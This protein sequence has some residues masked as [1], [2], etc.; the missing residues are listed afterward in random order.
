MVC[1]T[2]RICLM[3]LGLTEHTVVVV[4]YAYSY[5]IVRRLL[6]FNLIYCLNSSLT[7]TQSSPTIAYIELI[8]YVLTCLSLSNNRCLQTFI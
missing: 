4:V 1:L 2:H 5:L 6:L 8:L 7:L 3:F